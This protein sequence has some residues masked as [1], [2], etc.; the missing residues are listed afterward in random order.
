MRTNCRLY[1]LYSSYLLIQ[2]HRRSVGTHAACRWV[3]TPL[4]YS[5]FGMRREKEM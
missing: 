5:Q 4:K 2:L 3:L 1:D